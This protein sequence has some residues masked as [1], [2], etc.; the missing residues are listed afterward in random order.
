MYIF[1]AS[2]FIVGISISIWL[3]FY[4][5]F[6]CL[7][8][9]IHFKVP[10]ST[11]VYIKK[12]ANYTLWNE[13]TI[14]FN[15]RGY[16]NGIKIPEGLSIEIYELSSG[17]MLELKPELGVEE[18]W[19]SLRRYSIGNIF[20][21]KGGKYKIEVAGDFRETTFLLRPSIFIK[22]LKTLAICLLI[23]LISLICASSLAVIIYNKRTKA[24]NFHAKQS[25][26]QI[27]SETKQENN[28][29]TKPPKEKKEK[30]WAML[31]HLGTL[32]GCIIPFTNIILPLFILLIKG[33]ESSFIEDHGKES[34]NFQ[35]S[36]SIYYLISLILIFLI[37]GILFF[38][39]LWIF[40]FIMIIAASVK[41]NEGEIYRYPLTLR[42]IK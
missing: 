16:S 20:F 27:I 42:F 22:I 1:A 39:G 10:G 4:N 33:E 3:F 17:R 2:I 31:C 13:V 41:A 26:K 23:S 40:N 38:F 25:I 15:G 24:R 18:E 19:S 7:E 34:L 37:I 30:M 11:V 9:G 32:L 36:M 21:D 6:T 14:D 29:T 8:S 35:I 28:K 5:I 12:P